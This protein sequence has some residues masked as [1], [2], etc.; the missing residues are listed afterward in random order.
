MNWSLFATTYILIFLMELPD[1]TALSILLLSTKHRGV[2]VFFGAAAAFVIQSI[3]AVSFG[4]VLGLLPERRTHIAAGLL[5]LF[6]SFRLWQES[7]DKQSK[8]DMDSVDSFTDFRKAL[9]SSFLIIF[10]AEWGDLTQLATATLQVKYRDPWTILI[11]SILAL[12][13][14][15]VLSIVA[16]KSL[17]K[18]ADPQKLQRIGA[19]V[20]A[21]V[22]IYFL[23]SAIKVSSL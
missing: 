5:F 20:F 18:W 11:S 21:L 6:F 19:A 15:T 14:V 10:I 17:K 8:E 7:R 4:S 1:K 13:S 12:W 2:A 16:G 3:V 23:I 22:G 9:F